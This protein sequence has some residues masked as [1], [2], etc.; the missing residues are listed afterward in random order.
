MILTLPIV[1]VG[2]KGCDSLKLQQN[3]LFVAEIVVPLYVGEPYGLMII[4]TK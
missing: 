2:I 1:R 3:N 4:G